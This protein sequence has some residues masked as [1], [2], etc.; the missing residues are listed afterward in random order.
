MVEPSM[1]SDSRLAI[2]SARFLFVSLLSPLAFGLAFLVGGIAYWIGASAT[3]QM[4]W[5]V[6]F[7]VGAMV[8]LFVIGFM[9]AKKVGK[10]PLKWAVG[11]MVTVGISNTGLALWWMHRPESGITKKMRIWAW[12]GVAVCVVAT[13]IVGS[14]ME[15]S[16]RSAGRMPIIHIESPMGNVP[17]KKCCKCRREVSILYKAGDRCPHCGA[18]WS[19]EIKE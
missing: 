14:G 17:I 16:N 6:T 15:Q 12:G 11:G 4:A 3:A 5:P 1:M 8:F 9:L 18:Q 13:G 10:P 19:K 2:P 7:L